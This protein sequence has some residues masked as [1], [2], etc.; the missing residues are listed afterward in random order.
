MIPLDE[1]IEKTLD[2]VRSQGAD[3]ST[4][5]R[6]GALSALSIAY[7]VEREELYIK[8]ADLIAERN[9]QRRIEA[10]K[11]HREANEDRRRAK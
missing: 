11:R 1:A 6:F 2:F 7:G 3:F 10:K 5:I 4:A 9:R 8:V